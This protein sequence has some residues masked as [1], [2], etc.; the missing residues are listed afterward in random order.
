MGSD[1]PTPDPMPERLADA[2]WTPAALAGLAGAIL[3]VLVSLWL[4]ATTPPALEDGASAH[5]AASRPAVAG[6]RP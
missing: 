2:P 6:V 5:H 4:V 3:F 1:M